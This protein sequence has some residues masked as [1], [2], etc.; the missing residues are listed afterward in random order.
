MSDKSVRKSLP[1]LLL[2]AIG[3]AAIGLIAG[4]NDWGAS[5]FEDTKLDNIFAKLFGFFV[6]ALAIERA[7]ELVV[8]AVHGKKKRD[9]EADK[10]TVLGPIELRRSLMADINGYDEAA[11]AKK[12]S[13]GASIAK[14]LEDSAVKTIRDRE[15]DRKRETE[16]IS[17][18][19]SLALGTLLATVGVRF[20]EAIATF[21]ETPG[22]EEFSRM[23]D[24]ML[25]TALLA[26]GADG[27]HK[28]I[29][30]IRKIGEDPN[31]LTGS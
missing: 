16:K 4:Y 13:L 14:D 26:G 21:P 5:S 10:K 19:V 27:I 11:I 6:V 29:T 3:L 28:L 2:V 18:F 8:I 23:A 17:L 24:I 25:S 31:R 7:T 12:E 15:A 20:I 1:G 9:L 22:Q 30:A